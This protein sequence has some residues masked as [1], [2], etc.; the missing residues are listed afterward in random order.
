MR[1]ESGEGERVREFVA[2]WNT[3]VHRRAGSQ[4]SVNYIELQ[5]NNNNEFRQSM[6]E[7]TSIGRAPQFAPPSTGFEKGGGKWRKGW[8]GRN[9]HSLSLAVCFVGPDHTAGSSLFF[10]SRRKRVRDDGSCGG[11][12]A[13]GGGA[14]DRIVAACG[15][16]VRFSFRVNFCAAAAAGGAAGFGGR[17]QQV[18][19]VRANRVLQPPARQA[20][21]RP[22][23]SPA[24]LSRRA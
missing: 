8:N 2:P 17:P 10:F 23:V 7:P 20:R 5:R 16:G 4:D 14:A 21:H 19:H 12:A 22:P 24:R 13:G 11:D 9:L 15:F 1:V 18:P 3:H 6:M